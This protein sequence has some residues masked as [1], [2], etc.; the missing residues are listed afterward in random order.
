[1]VT[2][3]LF[4]LQQ[5]EFKVNNQILLNVKNLSITLDE[6]NIIDNINFSIS[7]GQILTII[8][9]NGSGKTTLVKALIGI[10]N[11]NNGTI[12]KHTG[13]KIGYM[14]QHIALNRNIPI[15]VID[16]LEL[17]IVNKINA[18]YLKSIIKELKLEHILNTNLR[19]L[20]G[21]E[22]QRVLLSK[23]LLLNPDLLILDEPTSSLDI[24]SQ[25]EFYQL[26]E[27]LRNEKNM[28]III[29]SHD[30]HMVMKKSDYV[31][32]LNHHICCEG[33]PVSIYR[34][35]FFKQMK[36]KQAS[37]TLS[38]FEHHHDHNHC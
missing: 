16:F 24:N 11:P 20:S 17:E 27:K 1:M 29:V 26:I 37:Q 8:G 7:K 35:D 19:K 28:S 31:I 36:N 38:I 4:Q 25:I 2:K 33:T 14:P 22:M 10:I 23:A 30:L 32:C 6:T 13:L 12:K 18:S 34:S 15:R 9:P 3:L 21:G 5:E